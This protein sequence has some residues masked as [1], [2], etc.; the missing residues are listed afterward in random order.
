MKATDS[1]ITLQDKKKRRGKKV[2]LPR[3][4]VGKREDATD[5]RQS[6]RRGKRQNNGGGEER[7]EPISFCAD[8]HQWPE[9]KK[10]GERGSVLTFR[11]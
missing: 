6:R 8:D 11:R 4:S 1:Q 9:E 3:T 10:G 7:E 5:V 2:S